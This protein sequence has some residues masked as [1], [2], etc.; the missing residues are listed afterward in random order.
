MWLAPTAPSG[1][2]VVTGLPKGSR[3]R[4]SPTDLKRFMP[5][6]KSSAILGQRERRHP[7]TCTDPRVQHANTRKGLLVQGWIKCC[8]HAISMKVLEITIDCGPC[9][10]CRRCI[11]LVYHVPRVLY[12]TRIANHGGHLRKFTP[13]SAQRNL[14]EISQALRKSYI[15]WALESY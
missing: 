9:W 2:W 4:R 5:P 10:Q 13:S 6:R 15:I 11:R 12:W 1:C 8:L 14:A 3:S 7:C